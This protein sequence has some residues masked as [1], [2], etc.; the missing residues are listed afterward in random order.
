MIKISEIKEGDIKNVY[1]FCLGIFE[2]LNWDKRFSYG[3]KNLKDFFDGPREI[4]FIAKKGKEI[5]GC[6]G[7]K[8]LLKDKSLMKRLYVAKDFRGRG[9]ALLLF[10]KIKRF[11]KKQDYK[12][13]V[14]DTFK[15]NFRAKKFYEKNGFKPF[16]PKPDKKWKES[17]RP[18]IFDY[19]I[20]KL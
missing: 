7:L 12:V 6:V 11:A 15:N 17:L 2:E 20:L 9:M 19:Y 3:L 14:L 8:E 4:F 16:N 13:I 18:E 5:I 1:K 10:K